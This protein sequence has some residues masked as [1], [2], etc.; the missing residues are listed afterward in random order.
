M[1]RLIHFAFLFVAVIASPLP[2][3]S[4]SLVGIAATVNDDAI[5]LLDVATRTNL[6]IL[7]AGMPKTPEMEAA[8]QPHVLRILIDE[9]LKV[10]GAA[11]E[12]TS[13]PDSVVEERL[14]FVA[15]RN[16]MT[17]EEF[18]K[19][20]YR[21]GV[22]IETLRN[23]IRAE[24]AWTDTVSQ[25][26]RRNAQISE[27]Q[28]D[29]RYREITASSDS[30][31]YLVAELMVAA[32]RPGED[33][34]AR[35][36]AESLL[37]LAKNGV[38]IT[39]LAQQF[40]QAPSA[41]ND[42]ILGWLNG[43]GLDGE[44]R[45]AVTGLQPGDFAGPLRTAHGYVILQLLDRRDRNSVANENRV[46]L[47][48]MTLPVAASASDSDVAE[49]LSLAASIR[50]QVSGCD[51]FSAFARQIDPRLNANPDL[52]VGLVS[53]LPDDV[54]PLLENAEIGVPTDT[55]R[56]AQGFDL[57]M[58]CERIE[59]DANEVTREQV[60]ERLRN[61]ALDSASK[62]FLSELRRNAVIEIR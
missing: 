17:V 62:A 40:S 7:G 24:L 9:R 12:G 31:Q 13:V 58:I 55:R 49:T 26:F 39:L 4:Q 18:E 29:E 50:E 15:G 46:R 56:T 54:R 16:Q 51:E 3:G 10:Q 8:L 2:A 21:G 45:T 27:S 43:P 47:A 42:G 53:Q 48:K 35:A 61:E 52:G 34:T 23:Q 41:L 14:A 60:A 6:I 20:L 5:T 38:P 33:N 37:A 25:R 59:G 32:D 44:V 22:L 19:T 28:I 57:Y 36:A 1:R 30:T 11:A